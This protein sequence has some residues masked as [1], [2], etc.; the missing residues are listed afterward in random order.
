MI[1]ALSILAA[2]ALCGPPLLCHAIDIGTAQSLPWDSTGW[3][4]TGHENYPVTQVV[5][6]TLALLKPE[7]PVLV[8]METIRRATLYASQRADLV[9]ELLARL[10][11][12]R[13]ENPSDALAAFDLGYLAET[14]KQAAWLWQHTDWLKASAGAGAG[15]KAN[16]AA[17]I[18]GYALIVKAIS[19]RGED[20]EME[21]AA[22]LMTGEREQ[23]V[24]QKHLQNAAAGAKT[25]ALLARNLANLFPK[26]NA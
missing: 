26:N 4:L 5:G 17:N 16:P 9:N 21:L 6:D 12:R 23:S 24:H 11:A 7:T 14:Y 25:D 10:E 2:P 15:F 13:R 8:R 3:N 18:D 20:A 19:M 22:A 1:A